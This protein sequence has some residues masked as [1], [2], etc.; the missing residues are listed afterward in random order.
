MRNKQGEE[1]ELILPDLGDEGYLVPL[2]IECG[3]SKAGANGLL[4]LDWMDI[5]A[6]KSATQLELNPFEALMIRSMSKAY[7]GEYYAAK[8][9]ARARPYISLEELANIDRVKV[10]SS[11]LDWVKQMKDNKREE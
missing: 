7:V 9:K 11:L 2:F 4:P 1:L 8:D 5:E 3:T 6:W 10:N